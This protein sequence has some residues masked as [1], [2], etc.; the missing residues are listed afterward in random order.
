MIFGFILLDELINIRN[1]H[2]LQNIN[3]LVTHGQSS[4]V[5]MAHTVI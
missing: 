5:D 3:Q 2:V 1:N 4:K